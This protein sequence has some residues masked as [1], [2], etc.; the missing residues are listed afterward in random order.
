M[1]NVQLP[2]GFVL[3]QAPVSA[4]GLP[5]GFVL[6][7]TPATDGTDVHLQPGER[8]LTVGRDRSAGQSGTGA[9]GPSMSEAFGRGIAQSA[10]FNFGDELAGVES[11]SGLPDAPGWLGPLGTLY[12][13]GT[14]APIGAARMAAE[15]IAPNTFGQGGGDAYTRTVEAERAANEAAAAAHPIANIAGQVGGGLVTAPLAGPL[16]G[17]IAGA[18]KAGALFGGLYGAGGGT[19][20]RSR[21]TGA[22]GGAAIGG[23]GGAALG[24]AAAP[25]TRTALPNAIVEA[26]DRLGVQVP[27]AVASDGRTVQM[28]GAGLKNVPFA[29]EPLREAAENTMGQLGKAADT[30]ASGYG[31]SNAEQAGQ[32]AGSAITSWIGKEGSGKVADRLYGAVDKAVA[33]KA[34]MT[35]PLSETQGAVAQIMARDVNAARPGMSSAVQEVADAVRRPGGLNYAGIK[36]LRSR[37]GAAKSDLLTKGMDKADFDRLYGALSKDLENA[38][39]R[40]GGKDA[41]QKWQKANDLYSQISDRRATL[42]KIVGARGEASDA[43]I[44]DRILAAA[45]VRSRANT[46]LLT[47]ARKAAGQDAWNEIAAAVV[48]RMGRDVEGNFSPQRFL[49]DYG[50]LSPEGKTLLFRATGKS[51]LARALDDIATISSKFKELQKYANPSGT[52]HQA[53]FVAIGAGLIAEPLTT[54]SSILGGNITA[55]ILAAPATASSLARWSNA[56]YALVKAPS[57]GTLTALRLAS[58]NFGSTVADKLGV[59]AVGDRL[60]GAIASHA[61]GQNQNAPRPGN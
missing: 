34:G 37:I 41:L 2:P 51:D 60:F 56:Y 61:T 33:G 57:I 35:H 30:I 11:A 46:E 6:D 53:S 5:P 36:D 27:K 23:A 38:V 9:G 3:D 16:G 31:A 18:A 43:Q 22:V 13:V 19:D 26:A 20:L 58:R 39:G 52:G 47:Q 17:G 50:K 8:P 4:G 59:P 32:A 54:L 29:G 1:A 55:R 28:L 42:A 24:A 21:A 7:G 45:G 44:F 40:S 14:R 48:S 12:N 49:T 10:T 15:T 25:F